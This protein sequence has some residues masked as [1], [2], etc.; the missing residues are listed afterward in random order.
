MVFGMPRAL[1]PSMADETF[2]GGATTVGAMFSA[3]A[4]GGLLGAVLGGWFGRV[5]RQG[6][7]VVVAIVAWGVC[8]TAFGF[9]S[10]LWLALLLLAGAGAADMVSAAFRTAI[11]QTTTPDEMRGRLGG[12]FIVV[13]A[14]GPRL[15]DG[16]A[17]GM[18]DLFGVQASVVVGGLLV[19]A[20][21]LVVALAFPRFVRYDTRNPAPLP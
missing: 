12:V 19:V 8:I 16:R 14:G 6:R 18:A 10:S 3:L 4:V 2:Q 15:G 7:A 1:F 21:T 17:G 13:V 9:T 20:L 11:L 5:N